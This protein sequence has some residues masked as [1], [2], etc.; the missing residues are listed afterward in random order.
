[1]T[2]PCFWLSL[3]HHTHRWFPDSDG[4]MML[5]YKDSLTPSSITH[6]YWLRLSTL[7]AS[8]PDLEFSWSVY[9]AW[10]GYTRPVLQKHKAKTKAEA[11]NCMRYGSKGSMSGFYAS[12]RSFE[13]YRLTRYMEILLKY[14]AR[15]SLG[16]SFNAE[17]NTVPMYL[18][19]FPPFHSPTQE[20]NLFTI[21]LFLS[22][23]FFILWGLSLN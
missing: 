18:P 1:M 7:W 6:Q 8:I 3:F 13:F 9:G 10:G 16:F 20:I 23:F 21:F 14:W 4:L 2:T 12:W 22:F 15:C 11:Y 5:Q 17:Q 19:A